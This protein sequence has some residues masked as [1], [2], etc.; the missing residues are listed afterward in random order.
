MTGVIWVVQVVHYPLFVRVGVALF[1]LYI[2][3]HNVF[4]TYVVLPPMVIEAITAVLL[5]FLCPPSV[6]A[7]LVWVG[8]FLVGLIWLSTFFVQ[9]PQHTILLRAFDQH[10]H[11]LLVRTNWIRTLSW[12]ARSF[13]LL[14]ALWPLIKI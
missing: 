3:E 8:L 1:P 9:V 13:L 5:L 6:P 10:G 2:E 14:L 7:W 11:Q 12:T 4:I